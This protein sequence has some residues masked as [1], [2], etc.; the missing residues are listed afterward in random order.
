ML[1]R[2]QKYIAD[3]GICSRRKAEVLIADGKVEVNGEVAKEMGIKIDVQKDKVVVLG[4]ESR[5]PKTKSKIYI[6]MN[7]PVDFITSSSNDQGQSVLDLLTVENFW[8]PYKPNINFRV[9]PVGRLDKDSEGLVLL[10]NDGDLTN[11][12]THPSFGHEKEYEATLT[13][14]LT[15]DVKKILEGGMDIGEGEYAQGIK[16]IKEFNKGRRFIITIILKEGKKR[17]IRRMFGRLGYDL[18]SLRRSRIGNLKLGTLPTG[19]WRFVDK[20]DIV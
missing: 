12:L 8:K 6:A 20:E 5:K 4:T 9:Y 15:K 18:L 1:I 17:Q 16:I 14:K 3:Q 19:R 11:Q 7:K 13:D 10:T 2:L